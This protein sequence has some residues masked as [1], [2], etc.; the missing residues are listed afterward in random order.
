MEKDPNKRETR[1]SKLQIFPKCTLN[2]RANKSGEIGVER[3]KTLAYNFKKEPKS[4]SKTKP[5][6][7]SSDS[8][9][10]SQSDSSRN[11]N[12]FEKSNF[13]KRFEKVGKSTREPELFSRPIFSGSISTARID[14]NKDPLF[15]GL[16]VD[17]EENKFPSKC[18][19]RKSDFF[20]FQ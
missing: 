16:I 4:R 6:V 1:K 13:E 12:G 15:S 17:L 7:C 5:R 8:D 20:D 11:S 10:E 19:S 3:A 9:V 2:S 18:S 14:L